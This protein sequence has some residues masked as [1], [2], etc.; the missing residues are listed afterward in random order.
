MPAQDD[1]AGILHPAVAA[2]KFGYQRH[3][4]DPR[5]ADAVMNFWTVAWDLDEPY[6][7]QVLPLPCVNLTVTNTEADVTGVTRHRYDRHL[8]GRGYA[9]GARFLPGGF[10]GFVDGPVSMLTDTHRPIAEVLGRDTAPLAAAVAATEDHGARVGL[11]T[12]FLAAHPRDPDPRAAEVAAVVAEVCGRPDVVRVDQIAELAG[13]SVRTVQRRFDAYVGAGP[14]WVIDRRRLLE[15]AA[16]AGQPVPPDWAELAARLG[17]ADQ[18]HL[19][20]V[21]SITVGTPPARYARNQLG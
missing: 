3:P 14:Q 16:R 9:V 2:E 11:L 18:A 21:F 1:E 5:L 6:T 4:V 13:W 20:R 7:A 15:V 19:T 12:D 8:T 17:Y 10:R